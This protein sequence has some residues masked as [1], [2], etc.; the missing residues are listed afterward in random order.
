MAEAMRFRFL[1]SMG[2]VAVREAYSSA[3]LRNDNKKC[4]G[5]ISKGLP[6]DKQGLPTEK[7]KAVG[8]ILCCSVWYCSMECTRFGIGLCWLLAG[9]LW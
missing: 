8:R 3:A 2:G 7:Q 6:T 1:P 4:R 9:G 5:L